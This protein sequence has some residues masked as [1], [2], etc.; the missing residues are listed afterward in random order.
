MAVPYTAK[1]V[2]DMR[3][4]IWLS[5]AN[6]KTDYFKDIPRLREHV[7]QILQSYILAGVRYI[8]LNDY[9]V[10]RHMDK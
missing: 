1:E 4:V 3:R 9:Y 2:A 6:A 7:E 10:E 8:D 5:F